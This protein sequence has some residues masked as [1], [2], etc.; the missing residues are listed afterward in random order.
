LLKPLPSHVSVLASLTA[1]V[2]AGHFAL[3][4]GMSFSAVG[5]CGFNYCI[6]TQPQIRGTRRFGV[7]FR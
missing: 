2:P 7:R 3:G 5:A 6:R 1:I 4:A